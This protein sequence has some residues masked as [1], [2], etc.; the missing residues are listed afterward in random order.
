MQPHGSAGGAL[1]VSRIFGGAMFVAA[2]LV[3]CGAA[4]PEL[5]AGPR[6]GAYG[7]VA[8]EGTLLSTL[9]LFP[10]PTSESGCV[11]PLTD[12]LL[13]LAP[14]GEFSL[15]LS[16][17]RRCP[18][19]TTSTTRRSNGSFSH[20]SG[21][22]RLQPLD[23]AE[24]IRGSF[25]LPDGRIVL[26]LWGSRIA[27]RRD[28]RR[29]ID[30]DSL[31]RAES[32]RALQGLRESRPPDRRPYECTKDP[33]LDNAPAIPTADTAGVGGLVEEHFPEWRLSTEREIACRFPLLDGTQPAMYW[34]DVWGSGRAWWI[35][36]GD[37][38]G[39]GKEDQLLLL[40]S[41]QDPH[42]DLLG[43]VFANGES[44]RVEHLGGWGVEIGPP[45]GSRLWP[46]YESV[47]PLGIQGDGIRIQIWE[48]KRV[49]LSL[50][51]RGF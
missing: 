37:F 5:S 40:T 50:E 36:P 26:S 4:E 46:W 49:D 33:L 25:H 24:P 23:D 7:F 32:D 9:V 28:E 2:L 14:E 1:A 8:E 22:I 45:A 51:R 47:D 29:P 11:E 27:F 21:R 41:R 13:E 10:A 30:L 17:T 12:G 20:A 34:G 42:Q 39:D 16:T 15:T 18:G 6:L 3:G 43:V 31:L 48:K 44:A 35:W 38:N 19:H